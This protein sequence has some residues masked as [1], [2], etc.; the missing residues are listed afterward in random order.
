MVISAFRTLIMTL[1]GSI[2]FETSEL[3]LL[4]T[5]TLVTARANAQVTACGTWFT[6][7]TVPTE[8]GVNHL[9]ITALLALTPAVSEFHETIAVGAV[10]GRRPVALGTLQVALA[11]NDGDLPN[12][13]PGVGLGGG[14]VGRDDQLFS[15][16]PV[17]ERVEDGQF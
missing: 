9:T 10:G 13:P 14:Q 3:S 1:G 11:Q 16:S 2:R 17:D 8:T 15:G 5:D 6:A 12:A 4:T 7:D